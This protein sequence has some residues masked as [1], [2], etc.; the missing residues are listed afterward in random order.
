VGQDLILEAEL[1]GMVAGL[2]LLVAIMFATHLLGQK[3]KKPENQ[4]RT[5][6]ERLP[7]KT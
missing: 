2:L 1:T 5:I 6:A 4:T 3:G 7:K